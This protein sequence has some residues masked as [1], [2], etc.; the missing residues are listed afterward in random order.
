MDLAV[1]SW[2]ELARRRPSARP[3]A[4]SFSA[5]CRAIVCEQTGS[6]G[7]SG[8]PCSLAWNSLIALDRH[9]VEDSRSASPRARRPDLDGNRVVLRLLEE[10]D[11]ALAA[12]ELAPASSASRSEPNCAKAASS[13]NCARSPLIVPATCFI[14]LI[15][16]AEPTRDDRETDRD[17]R[18]DALVEQVGFEVRSGRR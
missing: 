6:C 4:S 15:C 10:L 13:R 12:V 8:T 18:A 9:V 14:A 2:L 17:G 16:A 11:D 1:Q 7:W 3:S 5:F